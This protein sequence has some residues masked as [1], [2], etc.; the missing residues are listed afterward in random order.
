MS[1]T[2]DFSG[3]EVVRA[4][5]EVEKSGHDFYAA[6]AE[7]ALNPLARELF[8]LLAQD[9]IGHLKTLER[10][11][12]K[13]QQGSYWDNEEEFL[14]YLRRFS[15]SEIFP[16]AQRLAAVLQNEAFD[17]EGLDLAIAAEEQ[18]A[19]FFHK[20]AASARDPEG[21]QAFAWLAGEE[22]SHARML[23]ERREKV[24]SSGA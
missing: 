16:S 24:V 2:Q 10:L 7:K 13:Y 5:M 20:A 18:F 3:F 9:E 17:V 14:P 19:T 4:A 21:K 6:M 1:G 12:P 23:K 8:A 22:E 11:L 15:A